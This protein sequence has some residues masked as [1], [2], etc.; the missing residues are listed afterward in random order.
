MQKDRHPFVR[1]SGVLSEFRGCV[2]QDDESYRTGEDPWRNDAQQLL[3]SASAQAAAENTH[4]RLSLFRAVFERV[5][6]NYVEKPD[7]TKLIQ[8]ALNGMLSELDPP[9]AGR[10]GLYL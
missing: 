4:H 6:A 2:P 10:H 7:D 3:A 1:F 9:G 8:F 5:R